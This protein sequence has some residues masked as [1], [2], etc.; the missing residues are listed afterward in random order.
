MELRLT[1]GDITQ[2]E[3]QFQGP[4]LAAERPQTQREN[5]AGLGL[6]EGSG[7]Q[8]LVER[9]VGS[10]WITRDLVWPARRTF[11]PVEKG[12]GRWAQKEVGDCP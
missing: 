3:Q 7:G 9:E 10:P 12:F 6:R 4:A 11:Q 5:G 1:G 2:G 8:G